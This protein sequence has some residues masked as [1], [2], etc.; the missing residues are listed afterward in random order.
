MDF[1]FLVEKFSCKVTQEEV[2]H[3]GCF[4]SYKNKT[5][6][7]KV[8][9]EPM[10][11]GVFVQL[12]KLVSGDFP[13][14]NIQITPKTNVLTFDLLDL[15]AING[16]PGYSTS[17]LGVEVSITEASKALERR[18]AKVLSGDFT[19]LPEIETRIKRRATGN[20]ND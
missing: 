13:A 5:T 9:Y 6:G 17:K 10:E 2:N 3:Y 1:Y 4:I 19:D 15:L 11:G 7:V 16:E 20:L 8:S 14:Y 18:G 12:S